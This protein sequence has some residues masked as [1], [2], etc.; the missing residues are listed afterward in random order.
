MQTT[1]WNLPP[2]KKARRSTEALPSTGA[3]G[4][5][6]DGGG[7][8]S[9]A[10][11]ECPIC[12]RNV[13][14]VSSDEHVL[15]CLASK[16]PGSDRPSGAVAC[17]E[18][19]T[20]MTKEVRTSPES[21]A[22]TERSKATAPRQPIQTPLGQTGG[23]SG[24]K[25]AGT[26]VGGG[27][28]LD[29]MMRSARTRTEK[30]QFNLHTEWTNCRDWRLSWT[31][32]PAGSNG[33]TDVDRK[34]V[35]VPAWATRFKSA[36][37]T[38]PSAGRELLINVTHTMT[39]DGDCGG[40]MLAAWALA[41]KR[42]AKHTLSPSQ[43][44]SALQKNVRLSRPAP[45]VRCAAAIAMQDPSNCAEGLTQLVRRLFIITFEDSILHPA[46]PFLGGFLITLVLSLCGNLQCLF[47]VWRFTVFVH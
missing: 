36:P 29:K 25:V 23:T 27:S 47:I 2:K 16:Q 13:L 20:P 37:K 18:V 17:T 24:Q 21:A 34:P 19:R 8:D 30:Q 38:W 44:K 6:A 46:L 39:P 35:T 4:A 43:L 26:N 40:T 3:A 31:W 15:Q 22:S 41:M 10:F 14:L 32:S 12:S 45:A 28:V 33:G 5:A 11:V 1:L 42:Q 7:G 9:S